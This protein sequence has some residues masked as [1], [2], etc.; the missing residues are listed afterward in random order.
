MGSGG[1][2][3]NKLLSFIKGHRME[4]PWMKI[5]AVVECEVTVN[6]EILHFTMPIVL[7][8]DTKKHA[9]ELMYG[10][11]YDGL[12]EHFNEKDK[13]SKKE[14]EKRKCKKYN[15]IKNK[16]KLIAVSEKTN[17]QTNILLLAMVKTKN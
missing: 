8:K 17:K 7:S 16:K 1:Y 15:K 13:K 6:G 2:W 12:L 11:V 9:L 4:F 5:K 10:E 14:A 3:K